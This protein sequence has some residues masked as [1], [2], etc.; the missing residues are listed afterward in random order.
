MYSNNRNT[1]KDSATVE[2]L[3]PPPTRPT[4][5]EEEAQSWRMMF[6]GHP[7]LDFSFLL[8]GDD[9][10]SDDDDNDDDA[11]GTGV[12]HSNPRSSLGPEEQEKQDRT[13][14]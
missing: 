11:E 3:E 6:D 13:T 10:G 14:E 12:L 9:H 7:G 2:K 5:V 4:T 1:A 8:D